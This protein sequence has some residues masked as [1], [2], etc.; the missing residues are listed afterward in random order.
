MS[1]T[2][3]EEEINEESNNHEDNH[4]NAKSHQVIINQTKIS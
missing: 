1:D 3:E 2:A 4:V